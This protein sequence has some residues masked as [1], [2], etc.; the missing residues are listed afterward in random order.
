MNKKNSVGGLPLL[1]LVLLAAGA[2]GADTLDVQAEIQK[3]QGLLGEQKFQEVVE[4]LLPV[5]DTAPDEMQAWLLLGVAYRSSKQYDKAIPAL[6]RALESPSTEYIAVQGLLLAHAAQGK[7]DEAHRWFLRARKTP[8]VDFGGLVAR[9]EIAALKEDVRFAELFPAKTSFGDP[10]VEGV[11][12]LHEWRGENGEAFGWEARAVGDV[13][14]DKI[15]DV[16]VS[17]PANTPGATAAGRIVVYSGKTG[18]PLWQ[19]QGEDGDQLGIGIE[20]AHDTNKDGTPDVI[21]SAP[22]KGEAYVYSGDDGKL[23]LTFRLKKD[24]GTM[25]KVAGAGDLNGDR[26]ADLLV[27]APGGGDSPGKTYIYSGKDGSQLGVL[28]G[29]EAGDSFGTA[30]AGATHGESS[31]IVVGAPNAGQNDTGR[32]YVYTSLEDEATFTI[33]ADDTGRQLGG[34]FVSV[35]GDVNGD[36]VQDIYASDWQNRAKGN[37]T[38]RVYVHSGKDGSRLL[39]LTGERAGDGFGIGPARAGDINGDG[40][41]DLVIG[42]WQDRSG[43]WSGGRVYLYSGKDGE[44]LGTYTSKLPGETLGFD[45]DGVGDVNGDGAIDYLLTSAW[46]MVNGP[47][48]GRTYIVSGKIK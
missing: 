4:T 23:L 3:A 9:E 11:D 47:R 13:D 18:E 36:K 43:A 26:H 16:V 31:F 34:M 44:M 5:V 28:T 20:A 24:E 21:A 33:D 8:M 14:Q 46:S 7:H 48:S 40:A 32:V 25:G 39:T 45:A 41:D 42:A 12:I 19:V 29:E 1:W 38:G 15:V 17:A 30:V 2:A 10:F 22:G 35:V 37:M 6:T 27:G